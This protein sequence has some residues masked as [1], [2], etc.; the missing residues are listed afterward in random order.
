MEQAHADQA[1]LPEVLLVSDVQA[2]GQFRLEQG[3]A[4]AVGRQFGVGG[5]ISVLRAD[6][7]PR[8]QRSKGGRLVAAGQAGT[9]HVTA[10]GIE[11]VGDVPQ[12]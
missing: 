5:R 6:R 10:F 2:R 3:V 4:D 8:Q 1:A 9:H 11:L 12:R 7:W